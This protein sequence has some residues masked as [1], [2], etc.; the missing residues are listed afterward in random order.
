MS[1]RG[2]E[3]QYHSRK[4]FHTGTSGVLAARFRDFTTLEAALTGQAAGTRAILYGPDDII[5]VFRTDGADNFSAGE[6]DFTACDGS[7]FAIGTD[8]GDDIQG[9]DGVAPT[10]DS[11][12]L[13]VSLIEGVCALNFLSL[14]GVIGT[15]QAVLSVSIP[16]ESDGQALAVGASDIFGGAAYVAATP[17][18]HRT[19]WAGDPPVRLGTP[20]LQNQVPTP[21]GEHFVFCNF[22]QTE[23][24]TDRYSILNGSYDSTDPSTTIYQAGITSLFG[25]D[26]SVGSV[27]QIY[28]EG[29]AASGFSAVVTKLIASR[30]LI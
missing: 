7:E 27:A 9:Q 3:P 29:Q 10:L 22:I 14:V 13:D 16:N 5:G 12:G 19:G 11:S 17:G 15:M 28:C 2:K 25:F 4:Y 20:S 21:A 8:A 24:T 6:I 23:R 26:S 18:W 1:H 30:G